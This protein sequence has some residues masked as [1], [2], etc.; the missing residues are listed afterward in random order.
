MRSGQAASGADEPDPERV[1]LHGADRANAPLGRLAHCIGSDKR[2]I[3]LDTLARIADSPVLLAC[4]KYRSDPL[5]IPSTLSTVATGA[6]SIADGTAVAIDHLW[7]VPSKEG[8]Q[9]ELW[10][11]S[12]TARE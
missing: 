10:D 2:S 9:K 11:E 6:S 3:C 5:V 7:C 8:E 4:P 12:A 1:L